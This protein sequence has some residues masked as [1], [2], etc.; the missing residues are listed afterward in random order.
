MGRLVTSRIGVRNWMG[1]FQRQ[2]L[3]PQIFPTE[4]IHSLR[5]GR[6]VL[7]LPE[8]NVRRLGIIMNGVT[9][10]MG[11]NQHLMRS[12]C[13]IIRQGGLRIDGGKV[14]LP[15]PILVGR[16]PDKLSQLAEET[17]IEKWTTELDDVLSDRHFSVYFDSQSTNL[18]VESVKKAIAAGKHI[19]CEKPTGLCTDEALELYQLARTAG[20]KHGVVQDKLFLPGLMK[21]HSL[22]E[23][24]FL[25]RLLSVRGEFGYWVFEGNDSP[26]QRPSW[27]YRKEDGGGIIFDMLPHWRYLLDNF[28]GSVKSVFCVAA[29]HVPQR[30]DEQGREYSCTAED[31][32]YATF[33]LEGGIVA[34][35]NSSWCVRVRRDDLLAIQVDG[36]SGS[37]VAGLRE[38]RVQAAS[39]TPSSVWNPDLGTPFDH[40]E[41]WVR[42]S[43]P[44]SFDNAFKVQ[45]EA[46]LR[47]VAA[48][49][50]FPWDLLEGAKGV[51][52]AER[53]VESWK[54][55]TRVEVPPLEA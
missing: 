48:E 8:M 55:G 30:W 36:M 10:R 53:A 42:V 43:D 31:A 21:L 15:D 14:V 47:H 46:F 22:L 2:V 3:T 40:Y 41:R 25:G 45:W 37:A 52:L 51:Q 44:R 32:A 6:P 50:P 20:V 34:Q 11:R 19:Y 54:T 49:E 4:L 1:P 29:T 12:I 7:E 9:G 5:A 28:F 18:R 35:F 27:N 24:G 23:D 38:C 17:A 26:C 13:P 39:S 16:N 33:E